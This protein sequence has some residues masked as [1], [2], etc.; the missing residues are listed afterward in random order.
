MDS[1]MR[2]VNQSGGKEENLKSAF[3]IQKLQGAKYLTI[4]SR[5]DA[6]EEFIKYGIHFSSFQFFTLSIQNI[7]QFSY[8]DTFRPGFKRLKRERHSSYP[9]SKSCSKLNKI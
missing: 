4:F 5:K 8:I 1:K 3:L 6:K 2:H 7:M 9:L